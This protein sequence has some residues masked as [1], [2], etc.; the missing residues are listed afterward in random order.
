M[1]GIGIKWNTEQGMTGRSDFGA[2][3]FALSL[4]MRSYIGL[5]LAAE[6]TMMPVIATFKVKGL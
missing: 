4:T 3:C 5:D 6:S 2:K 1:L